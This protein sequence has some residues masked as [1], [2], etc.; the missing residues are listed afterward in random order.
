MSNKVERRVT[1]SEV[2][3]TKVE[4]KPTSIG[5]YASVFN[6]LSEDLGGFREKIAPGAFRD[7]LAAGPDCRALFNHDSNMLLGRTTSGTLTLSED[8]TGLRYDVN[9]PDTNAGRD[10]LVLTERG[11]L[12][13]SSFG[14]VVDAA[15]GSE[16]WYDA[17]G[18]E[19]RKW[20]GVLRIINK[21][22]ELFDVSAVVFPAYTDATV[23]ARSKFLFPEGRPEQRQDS[24]PSVALNGV[25]GDEDDCYEEQICEIQSALC[26]KYAPG[27]DDYYYCGKYWVIETYTDSV[28]AYEYA[29]D[30]YFN[31]S[32]KETSNDVFEFGDPQPV[33]EAWV[34]SERAAAFVAERRALAVKDAEQRA[35]KAAVVP[36][37]VPAKTEKRTNDDGCDCDCPECVANDCAD[38]SDPDCED[39]DCSSSD[40]YL[41]RSL[42]TRLSLA[43]AQNY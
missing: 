1:K 9:M 22:S 30:K 12:S 2:R 10:V 32:Y 11:D 3:A 23:E 29:S 41:S 31:I 15:E 35:A 18:K 42:M 34:P 7:V 13:Q 39:E 38:C 43:A 19:T 17:Q 21:V 40:A 24:Q 14:F 36:A 26:A 27:A 20:G 8:A 28:I 5:G 6:V 4:G 37:V 33:E 25:G 16:R